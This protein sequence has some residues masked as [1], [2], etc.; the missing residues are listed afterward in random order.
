MHYTEY[1]IIKLHFI[2][3]KTCSIVQK[4]FLAIFGAKYCA[5]VMAGAG[6]AD[7]RGTEVLR[8]QWNIWAEA[9]NIYLVYF[10]VYIE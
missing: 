2:Y 9:L 6:G 4:L 1:C 8:R 5:V 7:R 10:I 3:K